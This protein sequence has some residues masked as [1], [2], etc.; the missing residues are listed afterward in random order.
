M[1]ARGVD[2]ARATTMSDDAEL[3]EVLADLEAQAETLG[4]LERVPEVADRSRAEYQGVLLEA[5]L[6]ASLGRSV[7]LRVAGVGA[8]RGR[9][10]RVGDQWCQ[11]HGSGVAW[12]VPLPAVLTAGGLSS[13]AVPRMAWSRI[14]AIGIGS[15]LRQTADSGAWAVVHLRDATT[16]EGRVLRVGGDFLE[17]AEGA[18]GVG[19]STRS[20]LLLALSAL[21]VVRTQLE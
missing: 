5:R 19:E 10:A 3:F 6:M 21:A 9:L 13:R 15:V 12:T 11:V 4:H 20:P 14:D 1:G 18:P 17:L 8:V 2:G 16:L 7:A